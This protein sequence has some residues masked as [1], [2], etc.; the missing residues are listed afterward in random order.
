MV[1]IFELAAIAMVKISRMFPVIH[2]GGMFVITDIS[3]MIPV[4][5]VIP[6]ATENTAAGCE[7]DENTEKKQV[8]FHKLIR[9]VC[10]MRTG[11]AG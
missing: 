7:Q 1:F 6:V 9:R 11:H 4:I 10:F 2:A 3:R 5:R 8:E